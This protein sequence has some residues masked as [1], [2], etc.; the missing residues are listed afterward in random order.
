MTDRAKPVT[1]SEKRAEQGCVRW[2]SQRIE[3]DRSEGGVDGV[4]RPSGVQTGGHDIIEQ[5]ELE[6]PDTFAFDFDP[7]FGPAWEQLHVEPGNGSIST[8]F[9]DVDRRRLQRLDVDVYAVG[10]AQRAPG[11]RDDRRHR[12][13]PGQ[14]RPEVDPGVKALGIGPHRGRH[15]FAMDRVPM[16]DEV[17]GHS[18][19]RQGYLHSALWPFDAEA[20]E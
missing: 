14:G 7:L 5:V 11:G 15:V 9:T 1:V 19:A 12:A 10:D 8:T 13:Q 20:A 4:P 2:L 6:L 3:P 16:N 17:D 18:L